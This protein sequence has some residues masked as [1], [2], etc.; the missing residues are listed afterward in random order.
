M[1][2]LIL[3]IL[4]NFAFLFVGGPLL[5]SKLVFK[6]YREYV[7]GFALWLPFCA[8]L[9]YLLVLGGVNREICEGV[10]LLLKVGTAV[11]FICFLLQRIPRIMTGLRR[12]WEATGDASFFEQEWLKP[13]WVSSI[14]LPA[15]FLIFGLSQITAAIELPFVALLNMPLGNDWLQY[16]SIA[17]LAYERWDFSF[18]PMVEADPSGFFVACRHAA[19]MPASISL[20]YFLVPDGMEFATRF[21][22]W[23]SIVGL[24]LVVWRFCRYRMAGLLFFLM[25]FGSATALL[26]S[27]SLH[28][29]DIK[30]ATL[31]VLGG[32]LFS[33]FTENGCKSY[34]YV[35]VSSIGLAA[36]Y[37]SIGFVFGGLILGVFFAY[38]LFSNR[39]TRGLVPLLLSAIVI[40]VVFGFGH[41]FWNY[42]RFGVLLGDSVPIWEYFSKENSEFLAATRSLQPGWQRFMTGG[43]QLFSRPVFGIGAYVGFS[44]LFAWMAVKRAR[45]REEGGL[46]VLVAPAFLI[47]GLMLY[48]GA[49]DS[50]TDLIKNYRYC[51][52]PFFA[53]LTGSAIVVSENSKAIFVRLYALLTF[54]WRRLLLLI[55]KLREVNLRRCTPRVLG[56]T[57]IISFVCLCLILG[58]V[59]RGKIK[60]LR[61]IVRHKVSQIASSES[62]ISQIPAHQSSERA[63]KFSIT[64]PSY[65]G[66]GDRVLLYRMS[67]VSYFSPEVS[68]VRYLDPRLQP[69]YLAQNKKDCLKELKKL[70]I[71]HIASVPYKVFPLEG[72]V[73]AEVIRDCTEPVWD[74]QGYELL[75]VDY[76]L[77]QSD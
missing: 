45:L 34:F 17:S 30:Y 46:L 57:L 18:Y 5:L 8:W 55:A 28:H 4:I 37:H 61:G 21:I 9:F 58:Y 68:Y 20:I 11:A 48:A 35:A 31:L 29:I 70:G 74:C 67:V 62:R 47:F 59:G 60:Q 54:I 14:V 71:T 76:S 49:S 10:F 15:F 41:Y 7:F 23:H 1:G 44:V 12:G 52:F 53:V 43:L 19:G 6:T 33:V 69:A 26:T 77:I 27:G 24:V 65:L 39:S 73:I 3:D 51:T 56:F 2:L 42:V 38:Y 66:D 50:F 36:F 25:L 64:M 63:I 13:Q 40:S 72:F 22:G 16:G 32:G 75:K